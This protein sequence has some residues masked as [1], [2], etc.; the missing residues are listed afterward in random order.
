MTAAGS[1]RPQLFQVALLA[2]LIGITFQGALR[3][4][5]VREAPLGCDD[6]GYHRQA[7][8]FRENGLRGFDTGLETPNSRRLIEIAKATG[9]KT[10]HWYQAVAPHCHHYRADVDKVI[11]QYPPGTGMLMA[12][13]PE[14]VERRW[15]RYGCLFAVAAAFAYLLARTTRPADGLVVLG[16]AGLVLAASQVGTDSAYAGIALSV[17]CALLLAP[18]LGTAGT[19]AP[20][21]LGLAAGFSSTIRVTNLLIVAIVGLVFLVRLVRSRSRSDGASLMAYSAGSMAGLA[22]AIWAN[23]VNAGSIFRTTYSAVDATKPEFDLDDILRGIAFYFGD[24]SNGLALTLSL[25]IG[26]ATLLAHPRSVAMSVAAWVMALSLAYLVPKDVLVPYYLLSAAAFLTTVSVAVLIGLPEPTKPARGWT[27]W[28]F[29]AAVAVAA[30]V[31]LMAIA[32][33]S[34]RL[35]IDP[36]VKQRF[37]DDPIVWGDVYGSAVV[38]RYGA[39]SAKI[40]FTSP[41]IQDALVSGL[42]DAGIEQFFLVDTDSMAAVVD[43]VR[44]RWL[45]TPAGDVFGR[46]L[47]RLSG[48]LAAG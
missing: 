23:F 27:A 9:E 18:A 30:V 6:F 43:R 46:P 20:A 35:A 48:R 47:Y 40:M 24:N 37:A 45:L 38:A 41:E 17:V 5:G 1:Q 34:Q 14:D 39:Y 12:P 4:P 11:L 44:T 21:L 16:G 10:S 13:L 36:A 3:L 25:V 15:L 26:I 29:P 19:L 32:F 33:P 31:G 22:P 42:D 2:V 8:L 7:A 28:A